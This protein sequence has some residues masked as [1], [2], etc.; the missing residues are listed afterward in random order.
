MTPSIFVIDTSYLLELF[1]VPGHSK[2]S[3]VEEVKKR[4]EYAIETG[5]RFYV[6]LPCIFELGNHI[7]K[8]N[9]GNI[10][11]KLGKE[12]YETV[13]SCVNENM[14]WNITPATGIELLPK[15]CEAFSNKYVIQ[16]VG[17]TDAFIVQEANRLKKTYSKH[18]VKVHIW[19][20]DQALKA[21]EPDKENNAF[22]GQSENFL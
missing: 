5:G 15:L 1:R 21:Q 6:P 2:V 11:R 20:K 4:F 7:A 10:R 13:Q 12:L 19:T 18:K 17:L 3:A 8:V 14:P 16:G 22:I 9:D